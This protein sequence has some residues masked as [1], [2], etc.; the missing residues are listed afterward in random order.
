MK[1]EE[2]KR[3]KAGRPVKKEWQIPE[4]RRDGSLILEHGAW[5]GRLWYLAPQKGRALRQSSEDR[6]EPLEDLK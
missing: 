5:E 1:K 3:S 6:R 2:E 4:E